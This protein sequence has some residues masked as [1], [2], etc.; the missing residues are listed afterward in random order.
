MGC[1]LCSWKYFKGIQT[2][3][4]KNAFKMIYN[5]GNTINL[6][7]NQYSLFLLQFRWLLGGYQFSHAHFFPR[8]STSLSI[9][10]SSLLLIAFLI[11]AFL[12]LSS[13]F[14]LNPSI[15]SFYRSLSLSLNLSLYLSSY[16]F[17]FSS[18]VSVSFSSCLERLRL[19]ILLQ[20]YPL[21]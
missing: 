8:F 6:T 2:K 21:E 1:K 4:Q 3:P 12:S 13:S 14:F 17:L 11:S 16:P 20:E 9:C 5:F 10:C 19:P 18:F 15:Y 7:F